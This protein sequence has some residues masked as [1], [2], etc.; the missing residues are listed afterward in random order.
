MRILRGCFLIALMAGGLAAQIR[1][2]VDTDA[3]T[4]DLMA[5]AFLLS[6]KDVKIEA[7]TIVEGLAHVEA[8]AANVLR[9]LELAGATGVPVYRG[10]PDPLERTAPF[11]AEWRQISDT[12]PGVNLPAAKRKQESQPAA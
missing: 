6:R 4:D 5:I 9:V 1:V 2:I 12:L 7:I 8:G 10:S 11:P 3:G